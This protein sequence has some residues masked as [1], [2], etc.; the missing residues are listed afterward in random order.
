MSTLT[1]SAAA[2]LMNAKLI[3][4]TPFSEQ[5]SL[6]TGVKTDTR[7]LVPGDLFVALKGERVDGHDLIL[8]AEA[9]GASGVVVNRMV[10]TRLPI[11]LV[12]DTL[13][14]LGLLAKAYR[15]SFQIPIVAVTGSCGKTTVKEMIA[16]IL[17]LQGSTLANEG[18]LNTDVGVPLTLLRLEPKHQ[19]AVIE[20]GARQK[21]DIAY[22]MGIA[23]PK[24]TLIT[25]AG[26]AHLEIFGTERGIAEAKG[27]IFAHLDPN[28]TAIINKDDKHAEYWQGLLKKQRVITFGLRA[29]A[30]IQCNNPVMHD[31]SSEFELVTDMGKIAIH[32]PMPGEHSIQNALAAAAVARALDIPLTHIK[33]GL[34]RFKAVTGRLQNKIGINGIRIIDD[35]Y[36]ANPISMRAAL[37]VL[38]SFS[39]QKV[40][41][42]GDMFELGEGAVSLHRQIGTDAKK[43]GIHK[44]FG[45]GTATAAA[46]EA[47][48]PGATHY[49]DKNALVA[50]LLQNLDP[51]T[52]VLVKGSRG[53]RMEEVVFALMQEK[54]EMKAC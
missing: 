21:G 48:G 11:L 28:G 38:A 13:Q 36:N 33:A 4:N 50:A 44:L 30:D 35:T 42:M 15:E 8:D 40:F 43:L 19:L 41:V 23:K 32:L 1:L 2:G 34:E 31:L 9:R 25:N 6:L 53:M 51:N 10:E 52:S 22:L 16:S 37:N 27:E 29:K 54:Q 46:V 7:T 47:F 14:A 5:N 17:S 26:V 12:S 24:V 20:M 3:I 49:P 18:N 39:G 45:V